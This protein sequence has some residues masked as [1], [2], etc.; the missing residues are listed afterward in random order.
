MDKKIVDLIGGEAVV[1]YDGGYLET[2]SITLPTN[3]IKI[4]EP[5]KD[6]TTLSSGS[7]IIENPL[8]QRELHI[9]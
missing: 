1:Y 4:G 9:Y 7:H 6:D 8:V 2:V 3:S 5:M